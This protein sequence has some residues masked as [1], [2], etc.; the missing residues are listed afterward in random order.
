MGQRIVD[1]P[2][3][4]IIRYCHASR[5]AAEHIYALLAEQRHHHLELPEA[6]LELSDQDLGEFVT[7]YSAEVEPQIYRS[8]RWKENL[9]I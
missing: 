3:T 4:L 1:D 8:G 9:P 6:T 5:F 2:V 7:R